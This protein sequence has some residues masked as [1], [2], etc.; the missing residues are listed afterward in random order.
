M[1]V[2]KK[3]TSSTAGK[4]KRAPSSC[5]C[6][7]VPTG[8]GTENSRARA[9][10]TVTRVLAMT[11]DGQLPVMKRSAGHQAETARLQR[12]PAQRIRRTAM[13]ESITKDVGDQ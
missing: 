3:V 8:V 13:A 1:P 6:E 7:S 9:N 4:S 11:W 12:C 10:A 2:A 5:R